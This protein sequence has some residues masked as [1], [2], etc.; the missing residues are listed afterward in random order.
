MSYFIVIVMLT[1]LTQFQAEMKLSGQAHEISVLTVSVKVLKA[2]KSLCTFTVS[3][4]PL[5]S[6][7]VQW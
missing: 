5:R 2:E 7:V 6:T 4:E 3:Q 1:A